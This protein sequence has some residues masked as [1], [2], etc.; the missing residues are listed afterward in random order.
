MSPPPQLG[1]TWSSLGGSVTLNG[2]VPCQSIPDGHIR[3]QAKRGAVAIL[4]TI[5]GGGGSVWAKDV[6]LW[7]YVRLVV[8]L[9][10]LEGS[11]ILLCDCT[12]LFF[13][14]LIFNK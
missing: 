8:E 6:V 12:N 7:R 2:S 11:V 9:G 3:F 14:F 10:D 4:A 5:S 13:P 1:V